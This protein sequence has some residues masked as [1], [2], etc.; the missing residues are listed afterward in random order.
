MKNQKVKVSQLIRALEAIEKESGDLDVVLTTPYED[1]RLSGF[2]DTVERFT[3]SIC[4]IGRKKCVVLTDLFD[5][6]KK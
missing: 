1:Y 4:K 5:R 2:F 6:K 3:V